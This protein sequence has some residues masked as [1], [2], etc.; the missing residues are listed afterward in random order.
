MDDYIRSRYPAN[1]PVQEEKKSQIFSSS[2]VRGRGSFF[3][4]CPGLPEARFLPP[5]S[6][7]D[8]VVPDPDLRANL[9]QSGVDAAI[10]NVEQQAGRIGGCFKNAFPSKRQL[11]PKRAPKYWIADA[12]VDQVSAQ[13][14]RGSQEAL[15]HLRALAR[16]NDGDWTKVKTALDEEP[17]T[18]HQPAAEKGKIK[19]DK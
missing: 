2:L 15:D 3:D 7:L 14:G 1:L 4:S 9:A 13:R 6:I 10:L 16:K 17:T 18:F 8:T 5:P 11:V 19:I 12:I